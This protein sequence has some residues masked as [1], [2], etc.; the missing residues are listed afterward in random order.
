MSISATS[1]SGETSAALEAQYVMA[2]LK[3]ATDTQK[4]QAQGLLDLVKQST[5]P[6]RPASAA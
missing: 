2:V 3:K 1:G 4:S 5:P 6:Q